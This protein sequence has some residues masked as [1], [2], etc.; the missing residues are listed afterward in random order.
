MELWE[1][2]EAFNRKE[3]NL[4]TRF[5]LGMK[6]ERPALSDTF[7]EKVAEKL[8][9]RLNG[10]AWWATDYHISWMAG[11]LCVYRNG[12]EATLRP[13]LNLP[14]QKEPLRHLVERNQEDIDLV[15]VSND[16][17]IMI[18]AK[19]YGA[20]SNLQMTSKLERLEL[21]YTYYRSLGHEDQP[22]H[23][24]LL[25]TSPSEPKKLVS[26]WPSWACREGQVPWIQLDLADQ[27]RLLAVTQC[28]KSG[29]V[30]AAGDHWRAI[31]KA[32]GA[33]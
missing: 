11:A 29:R 23:F 15:L 22:I 13:Q 1:A 4:L 3:R 14:G 19:G 21:L 9:I 6:A 30:T 10:Q 20:W 12:I 16:H 26:K 18:E 28:D 7:C 25:I 24:H 33:L 31:S 17:L 5:A 2:L 8:G 32:S 27:D